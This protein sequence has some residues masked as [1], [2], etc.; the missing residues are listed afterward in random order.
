[1]VRTKICSNCYVIL[2][3]FFF[4][5]RFPLNTVCRQFLTKKKKNKQ[6]NSF[7][8]FFQL[9]KFEFSSSSGYYPKFIVIYSSICHN[10]YF[11]AIPST[12]R[13][14]SRFAYIPIILISFQRSTIVCTNHSVNLIN[15]S[16]LYVRGRRQIFL[17]SFEKKYFFFYSLELLF[18]KICDS[19]ICVE[20]LDR[21]LF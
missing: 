12:Y 17:I 4:F 3:G 20:N 15:K 9:G 6:T 2:I 8:Y 11:Y 19:A 16:G 13:N 21:I 10:Y 5:W 18:W 14:T 7:S 1:M